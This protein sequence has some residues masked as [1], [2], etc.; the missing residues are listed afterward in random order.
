MLLISVCPSVCQVATADWQA[1]KSNHNPAPNSILFR[2]ASYRLVR[3]KLATA[4]IDKVRQ[5]RGHRTVTK[6]S[7][8]FVRNR[9]SFTT[10]TNCKPYKIKC[11]HHIPN[12]PNTVHNRNRMARGRYE[13][14]SIHRVPTELQN[15]IA[16]I[17]STHVKCK[18]QLYVPFHWL[19]PPPRLTPFHHHFALTCTKCVFSFFIPIFIFIWF[20][21]FF[22]NN[23]HTTRDD[24]QQFSLTTNRIP[25]LSRTKL[26]P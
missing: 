3:I 12:I 21:H 8:T 18:Y 14:G 5:L 22:Q 20:L 4:D 19:P 7:N 2:K 25:R 24:T 11:R 6:H 15:E 23:S 16:R 26:I 1:P 17:F 9:H 10:T 13:I